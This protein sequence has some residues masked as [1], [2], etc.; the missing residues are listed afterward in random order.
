MNRETID[1]WNSEEVISL[2]HRWA[3]L[4]PLAHAF[5]ASECKQ[6]GILDIREARDLMLEWLE[7]GN[8]LDRDTIIIGY[9]PSV[10]YMPLRY[11]YDTYEHEPMFSGQALQTYDA[12]LVAAAKDAMGCMTADAAGEDEI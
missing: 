3:E 8:N 7:G 11:N 2:L 12:A 4:Y 5:E 10:G 6:L 1:F 9:D